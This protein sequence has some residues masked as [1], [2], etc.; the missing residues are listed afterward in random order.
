MGLQIK[1][2]RKDAGMSYDQLAQASEISPQHLRGIEAGNKIPSHELLIR[3][4]KATNKEPNFFYSPYVFVNQNGDKLGALLA[5]LSD[6]E[7]EKALDVLEAVF[8]DK[9]VK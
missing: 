4:C 2:A 6:E 5:Q 7:R 3:I 9:F 1:A 8:P